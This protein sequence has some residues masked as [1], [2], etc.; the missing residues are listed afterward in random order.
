MLYEAIRG[1]DSGLGTGVGGR[2]VEVVHRVRPRVG[3]TRLGDA[4]RLVFS[5]RG[6]KNQ[7]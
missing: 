2:G 7:Q 5:A 3:V 1:H 4:S 6:Y